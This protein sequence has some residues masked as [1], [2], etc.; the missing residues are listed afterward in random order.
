[1]QITAIMLAR[2]LAFVEVQELNPQGRAYYPDIVAAV[3]RRFNFQVFPTKPA[4]FNEQTGIQFTDGKFSEGT[5]DRL[6]IFTHGIVLDT[7][8]S[9]DV[10]ERLL[11]E[12]LEW[13]KS[14]LG[15]RYAEGM[16]KRRA[17]QSQLTFE[18]A[19]KINRLNPILGEVG[20]LIASKLTNSIGN[21]S[22]FEATG[23]IWNLDQSATKLAPVAFTIERRSEVPFGDNKYF[24]AA[25]LSTSDHELI[26]QKIEKALL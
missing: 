20:D 2:V 24:S 7:R 12:T 14:E 23:V 22:D 5:L 3:V 10:S 19:L 8:V 21:V 16:I 26:L 4:D 18:S 25:P 11:Y 1:M 6:Q 15:L 9:T 13:A 17:Y